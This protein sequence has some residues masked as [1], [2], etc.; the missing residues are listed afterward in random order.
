A[1]STADIGHRLAERAVSDDAQ[2]GAGE[3]ADGVVEITELPSLLP[4]A[5]AN[6][7]T[8][9]HHAAAQSKN[10]RKGMLGNRVDGV[11]PDVRH[12]YAARV[13]GL[14]VDIVAAS[15]CERDEAQLQRSRDRIPA[16]GYLIGDDDVGSGDPAGNLRL[17]CR[18]KFDQLVREIKPPELHVLGQR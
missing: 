17:A 9:R 18:T 1:E 7:F 12:G 2:R 16:N 10:K 13:S 5:G 6:R 15:S 14:E 3:V 4:S 11:T 8:V